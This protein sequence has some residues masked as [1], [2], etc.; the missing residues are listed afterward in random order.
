MFDYFDYIHE[1]SQEDI[2]EVDLIYNETDLALAE[3]D[4]Y[5]Q[6]GVGLKIA[7]G[8]G[9]A[10]L[11]GALIAVII[12]VFGNRS[13]NNINRSTKIAK[14]F[15]DRCLSAGIETIVLEEKHIDLEKGVAMIYFGAKGNICDLI[16]ELAD[17]VLDL[18]ISP[19]LG[20]VYDE[21]GFQEREYSRLEE[22][23]QVIDD[24]YGKSIS[25]IPNLFKESETVKVE[26]VSGKILSSREGRKVLLDKTKNL[27]NL[28]KDIKDGSDNLPEKLMKLFE[29]ITTK[30]SAIMLEFD[31]AIDD[32]FKQ[33]INACIKALKE[34]GE[35]EDGEKLPF[36]GDL[37]Y[38]PKQ[39]A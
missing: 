10:A 30:M 2:D 1:S 36:S 18:V 31:K 23:K 22:L 34:K 20:A 33:I 19:P 29:E 11:L 16:A 3:F 9:L 21:Q 32:A 25:S 14:N 39:H 6:E 15:L 37:V 26:Y 13:G 35:Y 5:I 17:I 7:A 24:T 38:D 4:S 28:R 12:K 27:N 8:I